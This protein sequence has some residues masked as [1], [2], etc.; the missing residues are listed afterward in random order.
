MN[1]V[2]NRLFGLGLLFAVSFWLTGC[3]HVAVDTHVRRNGTIVREVV[4]TAK[5]EEAKRVR[6]MLKADL[7]EKGFR[8]V[9]SAD[10]SVVRFRCKVNVNSSR[11]RALFPD[12]KFS[13]R[14]PFLCPIGRYWFE[15]E[16]SLD[17]Y[18]VG[19]Q[20]RLVA[21]HTEVTYRVFL[22]GKIVA[23][24]SNADEVTQ[25]PNLLNTYSSAAWKTTLDKPVEI[26]AAS[27]ARQNGAI[28]FW[29]V[30]LGGLLY[31][32]RGV[33]AA[34]R[35][36]RAS[37]ADARREKREEKARRKAERDLQKAEDARRREEVRLRKEQE[38]EEQRRAKEEK[39]RPKEEPPVEASADERPDTEPDA[40]AEAIEELAADEAAGG[41]L[42][43]EPEATAEP[44]ADMTLPEDP[45]APLTEPTE[46]SD[47]AEQPAAE[48]EEELGEASDGQAEDES[49]EPATPSLGL[50]YTVTQPESE[51]EEEVPPAEEPRAKERK[52]L[53]RRFRK[54]TE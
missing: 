33:P 6:E 47:A 30:V 53:F 35:I 10:D 19:A 14:T 43:L 37:G 1:R 5:Q 31:L 50:G 12:A 41:E 39:R 11:G 26:K 16:I 28:L 17:Q 38:R 45:P 9:R 2:M 15:D 44:E 40:A 48:S 3:E 4:I 42:P 52:G 34:L 46:E 8:Y 54:K 7:R 20:D 23:G 22:P 21:E 32:C 51:A 24:E 27:K 36:R 49:G 13:R 18:L 29:L 25:S